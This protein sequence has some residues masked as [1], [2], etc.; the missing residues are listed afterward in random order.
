MIFNEE[1]GF[2]FV[3]I[4]KTGTTSIET[5]LRN[6]NYNVFNSKIYNKVAWDNR[7]QTIEPKKMNFKHNTAIMLKAYP[8]L[9]N[10]WDNIFKFCFVRNPWDWLVSHYFFKIRTTEVDPSIDFNK[11]LYNSHPIWQAITQF[12]CLSQEGKIIVDFIGRFENLQKDFDSVCDRIGIPRIELPQHN[13]T[14]HKHYREYYDKESIK[15][16]ENKYQKDIETFNY[17]F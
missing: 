15:F 9:Y 14:Q 6:K 16:V 12:D 17:E 11:W 7:S 10:C 5:V 2:L 13:Q 8:T 1:Y 4:Q 3:A